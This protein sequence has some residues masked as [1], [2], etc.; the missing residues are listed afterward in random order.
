MWLKLL[1]AGRHGWYDLAEAQLRILAAAVSVVVRPKGTLVSIESPEPSL[2]SH[3]ATSPVQGPG[4]GPADRSIVAPTSV[5]DGPLPEG[6]SRVEL[7]IGRTA[8]F[9]LLRPLCLIRSMALQRMLTAR[10]F[11]DAVVRFGVRRR[12]GVFE[13]HAWVEWQ[14][15]VIGDQRSHVGSFS[16]VDAIRLRAS[17]WIR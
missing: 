7:A 11:P 14:G 8:R 9:G 6:V 17:S 15:R 4:D 5:P 16:P 13:S 12:H 10:G 3:R 1:R 2:V